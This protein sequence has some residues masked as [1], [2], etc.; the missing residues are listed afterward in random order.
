ML[1]AQDYIIAPVKAFLCC[2]LWDMIL[3]SL[4]LVTPVYLQMPNQ[5]LRS[6]EL[7]M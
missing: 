6:P 7:Q 2:K 3:I 5:L 1:A 4:Q